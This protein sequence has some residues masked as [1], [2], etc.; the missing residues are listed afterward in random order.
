MLKKV[1]RFFA[2]A[3]VLMVLL[4][5]GWG[6]QILFGFPA[7]SMWLW[8]TLPLLT[9][10]LVSLARRFYVRY[11]AQQRLRTRPA[12]QQTLLPD[13]EWVAQ[14]RSFLSVTQSLDK[15]PLGDH[16]LHFVLGLSGAGKTTLLEQAASGSYLGRTPQVAKAQPTQSCHLSF[17]D[18][19]IA[20][21]ISGQ[22]IDPDKDAARCDSDWQKLLRS[23]SADISPAQCAG[24]IVCISAEQL[25]PNQLGHTSAGLQLTR[26]RINDLMDLA[27][28]RLP[29]YVMLTQV[30][31]LEGVNTLMQQLPASLL[32]QSA[33]ALLP[34]DT[35]LATTYVRQS[36]D[37]L[38]R[39]L[40][41]LALRA[42]G[43][44][45][46]HAA[47]SGL[48]A[49]R[50]IRSLQAPLE[51]ALMA[52]FGA[53]PYHEP[54]VYRGLF[55]SGLQPE[56]STTDTEAR[57]LQQTLA[58]GPAVFE[59]VLRHDKVSRPLSVYEKRRKQHIRLAWV[60]YYAAVG[61]ATAW[62]IA[63]F[64]NEL[65]ELKQIG[66]FKLA[67]VSQSDSLDKHVQAI[68]STRPQ[69][70]WL[71]E[72]SENDWNFLLPFSGISKNLEDKLK[73][74]FVSVYHRYQ[75]DIFD[76]R[77]W[78]LLESNKTNTGLI[79][80]L[81]IDYTVSRVALVSAAKDGVPL[82]RLREFP[83]PTVN[84]SKYLVPEL[85]DF[86][87]DIINDL[88]L[89]FAAW[90]TKEN[91]QHRLE[92]FRTTMVDISRRD[93]SLSWLIDWVG[94]QPNVNDVN[95]VEYWN[96]TEQPSETKVSG[97][98]TVAGYKAIVEFLAKV[99]EVKVLRDIY[100]PKEVAFWEN[101]NIQR[102]IAWKNFVLQ[103]PKGRDLLKTQTDWIELLT[104]FSSPSSPFA[105][106]E[107]RL[108]AEFPDDKLLVRP[109]WIGS[110][111]V[112]RSI[113]KA[114]ANSSII[115]SVVGKIDTVQ[116][117]APLVFGRASK[118]VLS[119]ETIQN[120][121]NLLNAGKL[122]AAVTQSLSKAVSE[123]VMA[124]GKAATVAIDFSV[125]GR[126][127]T[128][129]ESNLRDAFNA[130]KRLQDLLG[131]RHQPANEPAWA[132]LRGELVTT[133][134]YAYLNAAC[135]MQA[136]WEGQV[137]S[138]AQLATDDDSLYE[139]LTGNDGVLWPFLD[140]T[141]KPFL[142]QNAT[143][144][145]KAYA[146][147]WM[148]PWERDFLT[149]VNRAATE[150]RTRDAAAKKLE[151][152]AKLDE[153]RADAR[154]KKIDARVAQID[155]DADK[156][157]QAPFNVG[158]ASFPVRANLDALT[159]PYGATIALNCAKAPQKLT[160]L[161]FSTSQT[162]N[163]N[164]STCGDTELK[165]LVDNLTLSVQWEGE[166]GFD[167]FLKDFRDGKKQF[168][169]QDFP[170]QKAALAALGIKNIE[171][172]FKITGGAAMQK[173]VAKYE[174]EAAEKAALVAEK[175]RLEQA[176]SARTEQKLTNQINALSTPP[177]QTPV[178]PSKSVTCS[179]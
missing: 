52:L 146:F 175:A 121:K 105:R 163:W 93:R 119:S 97:A 67:E 179:L 81:A 54:P 55:L 29:V 111:E 26:Q 5:L 45:I 77:F 47:Q 9:W 99:N 41:W 133:T 57:S 1:L 27:R 140:K 158:V 178:L 46:A 62:L 42:T 104:T 51:T 94:Q 89:Y 172:I 173:A 79:H 144:Y 88:F 61:C 65:G 147:N 82:R 152:Q 167:R 123:V 13:D 11:R 150:K 117:S 110:V 95:L 83:T 72:Q 22:H 90:D 92:N 160:Q 177:A 136:E 155:A 69:V 17:L 137:L 71:V 102:E 76:K 113:R 20:V 132:L 162:F 6:C 138:V 58:F 118:A 48:I 2:I 120:E 143:G 50:D 85:R 16:R 100:Q 122:Y 36:V 73:E 141:A 44:G 161:N 165:I 135:T 139:K 53:S 164:A 64:L 34:Y 37:E 60:G 40:P 115:G 149:F 75:V 66:Q 49:S 171:V 159:Q 43:Q 148:L 108:L 101:Y 168:T 18:T 142:T 166:F 153:T 23:M 112:L 91:L 129:K 78:S 170:E 24:I 31:Q 25:R 63:G 124:P 126:D 125:I 80:G 130:M 12:L 151:L 87:A 56:K 109:P 134:A 28:R 7:G 169:A 157:N 3:L 19:G 15:T 174:S 84:A 10:L 30:D 107:D 14:V 145:A 114:S 39:Y 127:P 98:Y 116:S 8:P 32:Q 103:F 59:Q 176:Q 38:A 96:P 21:E 68:R 4:A 35:K 128:V 33:G 156:F 74:N 70:S 106:I 131:S 154:I 86:D